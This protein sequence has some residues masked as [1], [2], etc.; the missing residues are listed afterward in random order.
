MSDPGMYDVSQKNVMV[1]AYT[2][3]INAPKTH[4]WVGWIDTDGMRWLWI[5]IKSDQLKRKL[6]DDHAQDWKDMENSSVD[7]IC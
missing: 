3:H 7:N 1:F 6:L 2:M 4:G 5:K